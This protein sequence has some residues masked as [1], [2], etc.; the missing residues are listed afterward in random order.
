M[1]IN[2]NPAYLR[3]RVSWPMRIVATIPKNSASKAKFAKKHFLFA[4]QFYTYYEQKLSNLRPLLLIT[5]SKN[6]K[7]WKVWTFD[8]GT[9][10]QK[11]VLTEWT[12]DSSANKFVFSQ[13][14]FYSLYEKKFFKSET[15]SFHY[16]S[17]RI[18]KI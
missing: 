17:P 16:F 2:K 7:I 14:Q 5:F 10:G 8:F 1:I 18:L 13:Q 15:T 12:N 11:D 3:Q 6:P 4:W 9:W